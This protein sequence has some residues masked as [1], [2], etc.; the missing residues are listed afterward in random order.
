[1]TTVDI[2]KYNAEQGKWEHSCHRQV[3][4]HL[5]TESLHVTR[6]H[7]LAPFSLSTSDGLSVLPSSSLFHFTHLS[8]SS[9]CHK[10]ALYCKRSEKRKSARLQWRGVK[11]KLVAKYSLFGMLTCLTL[12]LHQEWRRAPRHVFKAQFWQQNSRV[13]HERALERAQQTQA[14]LYHRTGRRTQRAPRQPARVWILS[15]P[16][17]PGYRTPSKPFHILASFSSCVKQ[18][19]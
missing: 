2:K 19:T 18:R 8:L 13:S 4:P 3:P 17:A 15:L 5:W 11:R 1:M 9:K 12:V 16:R 10:F 6:K 14:C 7:S